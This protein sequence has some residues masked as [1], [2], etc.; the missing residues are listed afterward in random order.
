V[1]LSTL[2]VS[3]VYATR[4]LKG[5]VLGEAPS[6]SPFADLSWREYGPAFVLAAATLI[7]GLYPQSLIG[8]VEPAI[9]AALVSP[10]P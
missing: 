1:A 8:L 3:V 7:V 2:V 9:R 5:V 4:L 10:S 6:K